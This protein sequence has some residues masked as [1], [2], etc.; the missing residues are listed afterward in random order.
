[1]PNRKYDHNEPIFTKSVVLKGVLIG[2]LV[3]A[4]VGGGIYYFANQEDGFLANLVNTSKP[5]NPA[6]NTDTS[7]STADKNTDK[8]DAEKEKEEAAKKEEEEKE[9][10]QKEEEE[11]EAAE[12]EEQQESSSSNSGSSSNNAG[13][14]SS[15]SNAG[16]SSQAPAPSTPSAPSY[17]PEPS[18]APSVPST[19]E[20]EPAPKPEAKPETPSVP[21]P[22]VSQFPTGQ[23]T[24]IYDDVIHSQPYVT[25][26]EVGSLAAGT[27]IEIYQVQPGND[28]RMWGL[29]NEGW[30]ALAYGSHLYS[31]NPGNYSFTSNMKIREN[32]T[33]DSAEVGKLEAGSVVYVSRILF[34]NGADFW[35]EIGENQWVCMVDISRF[36]C[37]KA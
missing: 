15:G 16:S 24:L 22:P 13:S 12:K 2:V 27:L 17:T 37:V 26:E 21:T 25:S 19:P 4:L 3:L 18:P 6:L 29:T 31:L 35:G 34:R 8:T 36:Y 20:P 9:A 14:S 30:V 32:P 5:D 23:Y 33:V 11:K 1:M 10:Q 28:G 7:S